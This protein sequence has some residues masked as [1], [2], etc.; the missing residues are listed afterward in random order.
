MLEGGF[1]DGDTIRVTA[2]GDEITFEKA[3]AAEPAAASA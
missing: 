3:K 2:E 1:G